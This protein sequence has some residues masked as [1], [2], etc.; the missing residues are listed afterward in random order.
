WAFSPGWAVSAA[1]LFFGGEKPTASAKAAGSFRKTAPP[2]VRLE[3]SYRG[4]PWLTCQAQVGVGTTI[5]RDPLHR[6]GRAE[7][8]A[9]GSHLGLGRPSAREDKDDKPAPAETIGQRSAACRA[10]A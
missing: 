3:P 7:L 10:T 9:S 8:P 5:A 6:A 2:R 4:T 1:A